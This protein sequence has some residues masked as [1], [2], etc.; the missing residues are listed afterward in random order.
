MWGDEEQ[1]VPRELL[2]K[3]AA[4]AE[5]LLTM[6]SDSINEEIYQAAPNLK[7]VANL[8]V[9]YDNID[10]NGAT[11]RGITVCNTPD[12]L[13]DTTAD[14][15]FSLLLLTGRR[16]VEAA[17]CVK[18]GQWKSWSPFFMAG[19]D[20]HHKTIGI[21][22]MGSIGVAVA[23]RALGFQ[24]N[25]LYHNRNRKPE[26]EEELGVAY[27]SFER[28]VE[29]S[30][31]V[32]CLTPLTNETRGMFTKKV[33]QKMKNSAFFIN[34]SRGPVVV[35]SDLIEALREGE[36]A[37]CGLDVFDKEPISPDHPLLQFKNVV[38]LPHIGSAS[39]ET[40]RAMAIHCCENI[41]A[42][43]KGD[44]PMSIINKTLYEK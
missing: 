13:T 37:G 35:E 33:F 34:A 42:V 15:T 10:I 14:L 4:R 31:Y 16:L 3:E 29:E 19:T 32:V 27:A 18:T 23:R 25:V 44:K 5:G 40:R 2:L 43:L 36:I 30:D 41:E 21:V 28:L 22:G 7:I 1:P 8:A 20:V 39:A 38:A 11:K 6:L 24:M 9:G 26:I 17:E 12:I